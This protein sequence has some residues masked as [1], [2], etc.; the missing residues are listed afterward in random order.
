MSDANSTAEK[1]PPVPPLAESG[2]GEAA[3]TEH[4]AAPGPQAYYQPPPQQASKYPAGGKSPVCAVLL[5]VMPGLGHIYLGYV[6]RGF[7]HIVVVGCVIAIL[8]ES[9]GDGLAPLLGLFLPFFWLFGLVDAGRRATLY[10]LALKGG[11][12]PH[13]PDSDEFRLPKLGGSIPAGLILIAVG[14]IFLSNTLFDISLAW[15]EDWWPVAPIAFGAWLLYQGVKEKA[16]KE[17]T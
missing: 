2:G 15:I 8:A 4:P 11:A 14:V 5:S 6:L 16:E 3:R 9:N 7:V 13:L 12:A 10:N 17:S 1:T